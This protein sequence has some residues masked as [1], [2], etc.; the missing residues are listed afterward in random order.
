MSGFTRPPYFSRSDC[1]P[2]GPSFPESTAWRSSSAG[3][4]FPF[5]MQVAVSKLPDGEV[6]SRSKA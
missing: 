5:L 1:Q 2:P 4:L 6:L 3:T